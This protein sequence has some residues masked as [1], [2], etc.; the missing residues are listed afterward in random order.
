V[1]KKQL[2]DDGP[3]VGFEEK[4]TGHPLYLCVKTSILTRF[5]RIVSLLNQFMEWVM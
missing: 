1:G 5:N 4:L 3:G 2:A